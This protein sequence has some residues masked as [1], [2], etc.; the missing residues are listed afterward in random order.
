MPNKCWQSSESDRNVA[1]ENTVDFSVKW[2]ALMTDIENYQADDFRTSAA[3]D[4]I[5]CDNTRTDPADMHISISLYYTEDVASTDLTSWAGMSR[6][7]VAIF[8]GLVGSQDAVE[9]EA[10]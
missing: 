4:N 7:N 10:D 1:D 3:T 8:N 5:L 9:T 6:L 2:N